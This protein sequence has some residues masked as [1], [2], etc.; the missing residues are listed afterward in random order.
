M[1]K[2]KTIITIAAVLLLSFSYRSM[3]GSI[4]QQEV[5]KSTQTKTQTKPP[6]SKPKPATSKTSQPGTQLKPAATKPKQAIS[7][8]VQTKPNAEQ[9]KK[10]KD[11]GAVTIGTQIWA[12]ANLNVSTFHNGD[13]IPEA[14]TNEAWV[15]AGQAGKPAW[16]YY[17]NDPA[18]GKKYGK[19]YNWYAVNDP[20]GLAPDGWVISSNDDW[21]KLAYYLGGQKV[22]GTKLK[23]ITGWKDG[24][25]GNNESGFTGLPG[26]YRIE[27]GIFANI[28][29][30]GIWWSSTESNSLTAFD[31][32]LVLS[33]SLGRSNSPKQRG[34][35]VRCLRK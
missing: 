5:Q 17:N 19:L 12:V 27:N 7:K 23:S 25:N 9:I 2:V 30:N 33:S 29:S 4:E 34:E 35:S 28:G 16:C 3:S 24:D 14:A 13:T 11:V 1:K 15:S 26:G 8:P 6:V 18:N 21:A 32:Y 22:A 31:H 10:S 20:R